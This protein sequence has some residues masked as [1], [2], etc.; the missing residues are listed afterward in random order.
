M[1]NE[2]SPL[3]SVGNFQEYFDK[4]TEQ[5]NLLNLTKANVTNIQMTGM[6]DRVCVDL[7]SLM[8]PGEGLLV[9]IDFLYEV[10][11]FLI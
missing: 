9:C 5:N 7:C 11:L 1:S 3:I 10:Q 4:R 6:G 2:A 8:R